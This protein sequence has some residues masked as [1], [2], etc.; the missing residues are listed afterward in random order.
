M[1]DNHGLD[2]L[3]PDSLKPKSASIL[4]D[5]LEVETDIGFHD[6][7]IGAPQKLLVTVEIWLDHVP[8]SESDDPLEAWDY[9]HVRLEIERI[10]AAR[11]YNLQETLVGAIFDRVAARRGV[12]ALRV[13]TVKPDTYRNA[14]GVGVEFRSYR[15]G[16]PAL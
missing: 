10:A 5:S 11:R 15:G 12:A 3:V 6:Y 14:R 7:E 4:L 2:G 8:D 13:A 16:R 9:D 1:T